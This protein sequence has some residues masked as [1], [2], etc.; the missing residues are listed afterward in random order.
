MRPRRHK[1]KTAMHTVVL[2]V[3]S[4]E[5]TLVREV[6]SELFVDVGRAHAPRVLAVDRVAEPGRV[7]YRESKL[8]PSL[9]DLHGFLLDRCR[10]FYS[11]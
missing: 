6:L 5:S 4:V 11:I 2:H 10:L 3:P 7:H 9:L 8:H 1:V